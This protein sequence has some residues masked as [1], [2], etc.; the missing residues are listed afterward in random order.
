MPKKIQNISTLGKYFK[1]FVEV[2]WCFLKYVNVKLGERERERERKGKKVQRCEKRKKGKRVQTRQ[3]IRRNEVR[4][5]SKKRTKNSI[6][7][8]VAPLLCSNYLAKLS[9]NNR[10]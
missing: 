9:R 2:R 3:T 10:R 1:T 4:R 6:T 7:G 5:K 8:F